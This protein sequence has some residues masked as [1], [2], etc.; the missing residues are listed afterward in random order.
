MKLLPDENLSPRLV[1]TLADLFPGSTHVQ[2]VGL[3]GGDDRAVWNY[4]KVH[5]FAIVSK[6]SDF[7]ER[8][9]L[10]GAPP[11]VIWLRL[12]NCSTS[13]IAKLLR[14]NSEVICEFLE[15]AEVTCL[16]LG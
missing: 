16:L 7:M 8:S 2:D 12:G 13:E 6:D 14:S 9:V 10:E 3:G 11:K 1:E 15:A 5:G 4:G